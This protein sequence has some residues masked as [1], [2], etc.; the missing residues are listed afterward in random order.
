VAA[1]P[2]A[3]ATAWNALAPAAGVPTLSSS[4]LT[5]NPGPG[6]DTYIAPLTDQVGL[7]GVVNHSNGQ[8]SQVILVWVPGGNQTQSNQVFRNAFN[9]LTK[10]LDATVTADEQTAA[11]QALGLTASTPPFPSGSSATTTVTTDQVSTNYQR[12]EPTSYPG[13]TAISSTQAVQAR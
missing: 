11:T 10:T 8:V 2:Q 4:D 13:V 7:V 1:S 12:F 9:V 6:A 5:I 3:F